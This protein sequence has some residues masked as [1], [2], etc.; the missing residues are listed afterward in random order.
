MKL[1]EKEFREFIKQYQPTEFEIETDETL[2]FQGTNYLQSK[3][4]RFFRMIKFLEDKNF[5]SVVDIG[6][7]PGTLI[8]LINH[9]FPNTNIYGVGLG[10]SEHFKNTFPAGTGQRCR[11]FEVNLDTDIYFENYR[12]VP[13]Y[14]EIENDTID[15]IFATEI[16]EHLY[17]PYHMVREIYRILKPG[18]YCY[19]TTN[20]ISCFTGII[21]ILKGNNPMDEELKSTTIL[22][23]P[24]TNWRGHVRMSSTREIK[25]VME[26]VGF[27]NITMRHFW[28]KEYIKTK[29]IGNFKRCIKNYLLNILMPDLYRS[30]H[31]CIA[32]K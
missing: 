25:T 19:L 28:Q 24:K 11:F 6:C 23:T 30:H 12:T 7:Y 10:L 17:N 2:F 5:N 1:T 27:R 18:G 32:I 31:E 20:N 8:R 22:E 14:I 29:R 3:G 15:I 9:Y 13:Q 21:R 4:H 16:F 26:N